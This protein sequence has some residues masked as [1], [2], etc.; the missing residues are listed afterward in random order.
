MQ[1]DEAIVERAI[2]AIA[3]E[4]MLKMDARD[5]AEDCLV[6]ACAFPDASEYAAAIA[7]TRKAVRDVAAGKVCDSGLRD[8][9]EGWR[10]HHYQH[11]RRRGQRADMRMIYR[12]ENGEVM[13]RCFGHRFLPSDV[14]RRLSMR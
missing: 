3:S 4:E 5:L 7:N 1:V 8:L 13:V 10:C 6:L 2:D 9:L 14:Y 12:V 11:A